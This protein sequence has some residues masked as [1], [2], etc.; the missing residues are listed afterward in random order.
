[1]VMSDKISDFLK[2]ISATSEQNEVGH[3]NYQ[4]VCQIGGNLK[5][6]EDARLI[7]EICVK[8]TIYTKTSLDGEPIDFNQVGSFQRG[9]KVVVL[10]HGWASTGHDQ[11][12]RIARTFAHKMDM[13]AIVVS[14]H[15]LAYNCYF[16]A[17]SATNCI[18]KY[19]A[20][21]LVGVVYMT[22]TNPDDIHLIGH[23]LGGHVAGC[24]GLEFYKLYRKKLGRITG[25]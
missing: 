7:T 3:T 23:S 1:M 14:W 18:G 8:L 22:G 4:C 24:C 20:K 17:A 2:Y 5:Q 13:N 21:V 11:Y 25:I 15:R 19:I 6:A 12:V 9:K 10:I 16:L